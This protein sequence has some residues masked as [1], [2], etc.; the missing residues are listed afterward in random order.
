[1]FL[2]KQKTGDLTINAEPVMS[3]METLMGRP[4]NDAQRKNRR[5]Q[6]ELRTRIIHFQNLGAELNRQIIGLQTEH[7]ALGSTLGKDHHRAAADPAAIELHWPGS[8]APAADRDVPVHYRA[9]DSI[10]NDGKPPLYARPR[11]QSRDSVHAGLLHAGVYWDLSTA[12]GI[13]RWPAGAFF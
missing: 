5:Q 9:L 7:V 2:Q 4:D 11:V 6:A 8:D 1:M 13:Q 10:I 3:W 12:R